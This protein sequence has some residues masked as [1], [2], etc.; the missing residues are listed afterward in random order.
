M[1]RGSAPRVGRT[2]ALSVPAVQRGRNLI[3]SIATLPLVQYGP[4]R[5]VVTN[6]LLQQIDPD[7]AN[8]VTLA[9]TI[10]DLLFDGLSWW[11][12]TGFG[13][14]GYPTNA[15]HLDVGSVSLQPPAGRSPAP[16]PGG[17]DPREA[18]VYVDGQ[19]VPASE[20]IRFDSPN[21]ALLKV[22][23]RAIRRA[24]LLDQAAA[25]YADEPRP[26]D[27]F[28]PAEGAD[29]ADDADIKEM[30]EAWKQARK[31]R[32]TAYV[33]AALKYNAVDQPTPADLQLVELQKRATLDIANAL[34]LD[35]EDLGLS[36]TSRTY[37]NATDRRQDRI[38]DVLSPYMRSITDRLSMGDVTKRGH[39]V[40]FD[41]DDYMRADP[42]TRWDVYEKAHTMGAI[43]VPEIRAEE[44]MPALTSTP[45]PTETTSETEKAGSVDVKASNDTA[46]N[47]ST[48]EKSGMVFTDVPSSTF[49]VDEGK[50]EI[51]GLAVPYGRVA[52]NMFRKWRFDAGSLKF[53]DL[54][55]VK[56]LRDHDRSQAIG[57]AVEMTETPDGVVMK[58]R[59]ARGPEGDR[60]LALAA[61]GVL[62]GLSVGVDFDM[63]TDTVP[64]PSNKGVTLVRRADLRE[65]SLTAMPAFDDSR[66]T[67]VAASRDGG[68]EMKCA[69]CG[70]IH[71]EGVAC[72]AT[73]TAVTE[74]P[75]TN[76]GTFDA[77]AM[78][79]AFMAALQGVNQKPAETE[80]RQVV[81]PTRL[82]ASVTSEALPYRFDRGGN[83]LP[84]E[85]VFSADLHA[86]SLSNDQYGTETDA[87]KRVMSLL[88]AAFADTRTTD[89]TDLNPTIQRPDMYV[90]Q[91]DY[92]TPL[93]NM[94]KKGAPP[95]GVN[96][97]RFPKFSAAS[98]LVG[99]HTEGVE[100]ASGSFDATGQT[101]TPTALSGKASITREVWDMGGNPAV[102]TLIFNQML[103]G[104]REG[105]EQAVATFLNTLTAAADINL[106][107]GATA[108]SAPTSAQL[109]G[110]W[111]AALADLQFIRGYDFDAFALEANLYKAFVAAK[112]SSGRPL[113]PIIA[114]ANANGSA[115][116]RFRTLDLAG[117]VGV[118]SWALTA[119]PGSVNNSWLFDSSTVH[120]WASAPQRL[121]FPGTKPTD[122]SYAPV[123][124][125]DIAI[126]GYKAFAN[127]DI[128]GVR[129]VTYDTTT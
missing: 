82:T 35:P 15:R 44:N 94:V 95:N 120:A 7:V 11:R 69:T 114:P 93:W 121:E 85:H 62:D 83:F 47:L 99:D 25:M 70:Q 20:M 4:D 23:G 87:G 80:Q 16:L 56:L 101:V 37:Q 45:T 53:A 72:T 50:R 6:L 89:V 96:P 64:D 40:R 117:V 97:F 36:T 42:R 76:G 111:E 75:T 60:A 118:P 73:T 31:S 125:I 100:P 119:T 51:I 74:Q 49:S 8:V 54:G 116:S 2:E 104:Y 124:W 21:P 12:I 55:R 79:K 5:S 39:V 65:V 27:F 126:W 91:R 57:R 61:D 102:S 81:N 90:D 106:N 22:A 113:Y 13:W 110:N 3:C 28:T 112:D 14:D 86:M 107:T 9:Q 68:T 105:L 66:V 29:P 24:I 123:A 77:D 88:Q 127:S 46:L 32:G 67:S 41:L 108:G 78:T 71:A 52:V 122:G 18:V 84:T 38:N 26:L 33:P 129:Q 92:R 48:D 115:A 103:R 19:P 10:E 109:A 128:G 63:A 43:T 17:H 34:G 59:V 1:G 58:F 30:L 98:G